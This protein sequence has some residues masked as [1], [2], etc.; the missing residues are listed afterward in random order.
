MRHLRS[1]R[2]TITTHPLAHSSV[3]RTSPIRFAVQHLRSAAGTS[4]PPDDP[5][6][7]TPDAL[8]MRGAPPPPRPP[9]R[10][11]PASQR[12]IPQ[13]LRER[14]HAGVGPG[15]LQRR[16][17]LQT[18]SRVGVRPERYGAAPGAHQ[19]RQPHPGGS[20]PGGPWPCCSWATLTWCPSPRPGWSQDLRRRA[21]RGEVG[22]MRSTCSNPHRLHGPMPFRGTW[23]GQLPPKGTLR[24]PGGRRREANATLAPGHLVEHRPTP[25]RARLRDHGVRHPHPVAHRPQAAAGDRG[26]KGLPRRCASRSR[27]RRPPL[28]SRSKT[29]N[30]LITAAEVVPPASPST[31]PP[32]RSTTSGGPSLR[33]GL[34][35]EL[36]GAARPRPARG[37]STSCRWE[38][39]ASS[40]PAPD[41]WQTVMHG[42]HKINVINPTR[43]ELQVDIRT[44]PG[45]TSSG[46]PDHPRRR[47]R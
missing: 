15:G 45:Q 39:P 27:A 12:L 21:H 46:H 22:P 6:S 18:T 9:P 41:R 7:R 25:S 26:E 47:P 4:P 24:L 11:S 20:D 35:E 36:V 1:L 29:D 8:T 2:C 32:P 37:V 42:G 13:R 3:G 19:P 23:P 44:L 14:R 34:P 30:A 28:C 16:P 10:R 33:H 17:L 38:W 43:S 31:S 5:V 40:T